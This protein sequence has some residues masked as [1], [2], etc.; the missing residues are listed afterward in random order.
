MKEK[1]IIVAK[2]FCMG[3]ADVVPGVSGGTMAFILGIYPQLIA[4]IKSFDMQ[5]L[6]GLCRLDRP[7]IFSHP[8]FSFLVPLV[9]GIV[10]ALLFFTRVISIPL[11]I[12]TH[13]ELVYGLFFGLI[14]GSIIVLFRQLGRLTIKEGVFIVTGTIIGWFLFNIVPASTP[15][16][17]WFI[18]L[19][20]ALSICAML[21]PGISGSF[22]LLMLKKYA[23]IFNAIGF[24]QFAVIIPFIL[25]VI[26]GLILFSR[27]LAY[28]LN[29]Y[30]RPTIMF[31][32]GLLCASL[33]VIWP[34]QERVYEIIRGKEHLI[35]SVP[36]IPDT[37]SLNIS[38]SV[39][40][41]MLGLLAILLINRFAQRRK[42]TADD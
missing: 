13:P 37:L 9:L 2:G 5:W 35:K 15:N 38:F 39:F 12:R 31:I 23:Y 30:Y 6:K 41:C 42:V 22:I 1:S 11:L 24:F 18:F 32:L 4:A 3:A 26:S 8:H 28:L 17:S 20:G 36:V 19:C 16:D 25:G 7:I 34:F 10:V 29:N 33:W 21:L 14:V 40:M 27:I